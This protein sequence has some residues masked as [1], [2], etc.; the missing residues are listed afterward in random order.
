MIG[1][2]GLYTSTISQRRVSKPQQRDRGSLQ[3]FSGDLR[4]CLR[5]CPVL[6]LCHGRNRWAWTDGLCLRLGRESYNAV[7]AST[8]FSQL[9][10]RLSVN[11]TIRCVGRS[12]SESR[13]WFNAVHV[14]TNG[15]CVSDTGTYAIIVWTVCTTACRLENCETSLPP[16]VAE[17]IMRK[18]KMHEYD[19]WQRARR[20]H[21]LPVCTHA[22]REKP[23]Q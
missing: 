7:H 13:Y 22:C 5:L 9:M 4:A 8:H 2:A 17:M 10:S 6:Q 23:T 12:C 18:G 15:T 20:A 11:P 1:T 14:R 3:S 21:W 16:A 19:H